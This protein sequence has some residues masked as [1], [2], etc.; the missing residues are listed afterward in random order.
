L[1]LEIAK[2]V[3]VV[4]VCQTPKPMM[5]VLACHDVAGATELEKVI[6]T[7]PSTSCLTNPVAGISQVMNKFISPKYHSTMD[8]PIK[9]KGSE[10]V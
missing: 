5:T 4:R 7:K 2:L 6:V 10:L 3:R 1:L 9:M 8:L